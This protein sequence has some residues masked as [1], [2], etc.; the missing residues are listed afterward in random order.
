VDPHA[1][2]L[3]AHLAIRKLLNTGR[4]RP[5]PRHWM[6]RLAEP[7]TTYVYSVNHPGVGVVVI[8]GTALTVITRELNRTT[9]LRV[10]QPVG[11]RPRCT[12]PPIPVYLDD[13]LAA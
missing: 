6:R 7:G 11:R 12:P 2:W 3:N 5:N 4:S 10:V 13:D 9:T 1:S 8:D